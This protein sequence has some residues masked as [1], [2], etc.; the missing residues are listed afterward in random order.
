MTC[1]QWKLEQEIG[2]PQRH[3]N[4]AF[5]I[6]MVGLV[7]A[8]GG[9]SSECDPVELCP[10]MDE[11]VGNCH[12]QGW[13]IC[14]D[15]LG[16]DDSD[17]WYVVEL[18]SG[19][20]IVIKEK[21]LKDISLLRDCLEARHTWWQSKYGKNGDMEVDCIA[22]Q[23]AGSSVGL[24]A[25]AL[26]TCLDV[27]CQKVLVFDMIGVEGLSVVSADTRLELPKIPHGFEIDLSAKYT[28]WHSVVIDRGGRVEV[29]G[30]SVPDEREL[31]SIFVKFRRAQRK[32]EPQMFIRADCRLSFT[33]VFKVLRAAT[34]AGI[35]R[36]YLVGCTDEKTG[37]AKVVP[38]NL[39]CP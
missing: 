21:R 18:G 33:H 20:E 25:S 37:C 5:P 10:E 38:I 12:K 9:C 19:G 39:P 30:V 14:E 35:W 36:H 1:C 17:E 6:V 15:G 13:G 11:A 2:R 23:I 27:H 34:A 7:F 28:N 29:E 22:L 32:H 24:V 8:C 16:E 26:D 31:Q 4:P 3:Y